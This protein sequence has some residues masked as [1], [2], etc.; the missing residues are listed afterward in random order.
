M[1][2]KKFVKPALFGGKKQWEDFVNKHEVRD[3]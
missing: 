2:E 3:N 1:E